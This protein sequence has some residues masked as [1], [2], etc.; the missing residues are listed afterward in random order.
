MPVRVEADSSAFEALVDPGAQLTR[1]G[2]GYQ[3][4]EGPVWSARERCLYFSDIPS[5]DR[6]RWSAERGMELDAHLTFKANGLVIDTHG[7]LVACEQVSSCVVRMRPDGARELLAYHH[8]GHYL[9]SPNDIVV[10]AADGAIYFTD[11]D[12]GRWNDWIGQERSRELGFRGVYRVPDRSD[13]EAQLLVDEDE[14]DQPNGLCFSPDEHVLYVND[15][16]N[17]HIKA[18]D[19]AP[20]GRIRTTQLDSCSQ[21]TRAPCASMTSPFALNVRCAS[22]SIPRS[23]LQRQRSSEGMS[24]K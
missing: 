5:D 9:N 24:E 23:A 13:G 11:P 4:S 6:W 20:S 17:A 10:R 2:E 16:D 12:Y 21:A 18:F 14:F 7:A 8:G 19:V 3:F 22:S 15:S 1:L